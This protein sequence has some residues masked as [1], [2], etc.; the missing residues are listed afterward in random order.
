L[1]H[2]SLRPG[3]PTAPQHDRALQVIDSPSSGCPSLAVPAGFGPG[4]LPIGIQIVGP[5]RKELDCLQL[6]AA[7]EAATN[8]TRTRRPTLL[9]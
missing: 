7:Y 9:G 1:N 5:N 8:L 4:G 3:C 2:A 6:A